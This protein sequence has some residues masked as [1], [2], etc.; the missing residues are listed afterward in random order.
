MSRGKVLKKSLFKGVATALVTPFGKTG[1]IDFLRLD[2]LIKR[3]ISFGVDAIVVCGTTGEAPTLSDKEH[4]SVIEQAVI[5][6]NGKIPVI[7]GTGSNDT[8]HAI[9]MTRE[10]KKLG[11]SGALIVTP[12]YNK[13]CQNGLIAHFLQISDSADMPIIIYNAPKRTGVDIEI[14]TYKKLFENANIVGVKECSDSVKR[15]N[16]LMMIKNDVS[17]YVGNDCGIF[18]Y[19][20]AGADGVISVVSNVLPSQISNIVNRLLNGEY[21]KAKTALQKYKSVIELL[22]VSPNPV[23]VKYV[24]S[25]LKLCDNRLRAPLL[26]LKRLNNVDIIVNEIK[27]ELSL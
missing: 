1:K 10:A 4:L 3:Q 18:P 27:G 22:S 7:A 2:Y 23:T 19:M 6:C 15:L 17:V 13:P 9:I 8:S 11:A 21:G 26:P 14:D 25:K 24:L 20:T 16:D 12:Y 5:S